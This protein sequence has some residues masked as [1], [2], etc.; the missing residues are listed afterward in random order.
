[1]IAR[2]VD[3]AAAAAPINAAA[4]PNRRRLSAAITWL[5]RT[6]IGTRWPL[7]AAAVASSRNARV[8]LAAIYAVSAAEIGVQG[9]RVTR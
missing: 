5:L 6:S 9:G 2:A 3:G 7:Y 8:A 4:A 1:M